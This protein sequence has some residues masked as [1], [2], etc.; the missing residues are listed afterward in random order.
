VAP[1]D[2]LTVTGTFIGLTPDGTEATNSQHRDLRQD[3]A[4][5]TIGGSLPAT[6]NVI[7]GGFDGILVSSDDPGIVIE[8]NYIGT[9][10]SGRL[11]RGAAIGVRIVQWGLGCGR[12]ECQRRPTGSASTTTMASS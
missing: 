7:A 4:D 5:V 8:N 12:R 10:P 9:D 6:R 1:A 2:G 11:D 3:G